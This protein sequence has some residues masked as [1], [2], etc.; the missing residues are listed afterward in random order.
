MS[1]RAGVAVGAIVITVLL[2]VLGASTWPRDPA[3][4]R[5][6]AS[7]AVQGTL[8]A[9]GTVALLADAHQRGRTSA[10][11]ES[12]VLAQARKA[13]ATAQEE[14]TTNEIPDAESAKLRDRLVPL[15]VRAQVL[16]TN[17]RGGLEDR[18]GLN[19]LADDLRAF[20]DELR[21]SG[22]SGSPLAS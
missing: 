2:G 21:W 20:I 7:Q 11:Y 17:G 15:L 5:D 14:M 13:V 18:A 16:L 6:T 19:Q 9:V 10:P 8:S 4:Y 1:L 3:Q 12:V 22:Y